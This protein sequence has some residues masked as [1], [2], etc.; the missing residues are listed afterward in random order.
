MQ[1]LAKVKQKHI[2]GTHKTRIYS[3]PYHNGGISGLIPM[4]FEDKNGI[5]V[6]YDAAT[7]QKQRESDEISILSHELLSPL[8]LIK[9]YAVT[10]LELGTVI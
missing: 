9:G 10:L 2:T 4:L 5:P 8:T 6:I 7:Q 3:F 1:G